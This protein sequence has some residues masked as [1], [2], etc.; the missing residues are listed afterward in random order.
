MTKS[1]RTYSVHLG[2]IFALLADWNVAQ[3]KA[4]AHINPAFSKRKKK[5]H[6][7]GVAGSTNGVS[8]NL[9]RGQN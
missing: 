8:L 6:F 7:T 3:L 2:H 9:P 5:G 4:A 1:V